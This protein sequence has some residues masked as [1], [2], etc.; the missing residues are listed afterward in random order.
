MVVSK[1]MRIFAPQSG[2]WENPGIALVKSSLVFVLVGGCR[3][4]APKFLSIRHK[5]KGLNNP[6]DFANILTAVCIKPLVNA[7]PHL[8]TYYRIQ[9]VG[10][11][12]LDGRCTS[13]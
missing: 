11:T 7:V 8:D 13:H 5:K 3:L 12:Y 6:Y 1:T 10:C 9:E 2:I 4:V